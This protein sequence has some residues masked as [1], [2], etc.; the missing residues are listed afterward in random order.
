[1]EFGIPKNTQDDKFYQIKLSENNSQVKQLCF[2]A[3]QKKNE[4]YI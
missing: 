3:Q 4:T 1:M 2:F